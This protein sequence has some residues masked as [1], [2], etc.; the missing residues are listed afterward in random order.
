MVERYKYQKVLKSA[1]TEDF[2]PLTTDMTYPL[3]SPL[4]DP[5]PIAT[6]VITVFSDVHRNGHLFSPVAYQ[7]LHG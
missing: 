1:T 5:R 6:A 3:Q 2:F 4:S 7:H